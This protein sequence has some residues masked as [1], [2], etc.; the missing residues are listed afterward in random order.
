[1]RCDAFIKNHYKKSPT[2]A[3]SLRHPRCRAWALDGSTRCRMH[4]GLS[5]GPKT[6]EGKANVVAAMV[7]GRRK[8]VERLHSEGKRAPGGR[9]KGSGWLTSAMIARARLE[10]RRFGVTQVP[11]DRALVIA[12]LRSAKG[13]PQGETRTKELLAASKRAAMGEDIEKAK[14]IIRELI[15]DID[16]RFRSPR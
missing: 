2:G 5:T 11:P 3:R 16:D 9:K 1:M 15:P 12:L 14:S 4:G 13:N 6:P 10:A 7:A 8:W